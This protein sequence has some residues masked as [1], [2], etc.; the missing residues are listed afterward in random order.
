MIA[1]KTLLDYT[2]FFSRNDYKRN[3]TKIIFMT[4]QNL[5]LDFKLK[6]IEEKNHFLERTKQKDLKGKKHRKF[7]QL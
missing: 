2:E 1:G 3:Q 4:K 6:N 7:T 5:S